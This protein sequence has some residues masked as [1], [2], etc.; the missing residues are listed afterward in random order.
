MM[1]R[2][3]LLPGILFARVRRQGAPNMFDQ[4]IKAIGC[5]AATLR[6]VPSMQGGKAV[7]KP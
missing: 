2:L 4:A 5:I 6:V 3:V 1:Q 7:R